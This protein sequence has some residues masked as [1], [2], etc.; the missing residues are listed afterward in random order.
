M[1]EIE[2]FGQVPW[3]LIGLSRDDHENRQVRYSIM[4]WIGSQW[5]LSSTGWAWDGRDTCLT[6]LAI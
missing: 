5:K 4:H 3:L 1:T 6:F 2:V